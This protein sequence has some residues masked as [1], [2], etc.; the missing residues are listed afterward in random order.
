LMRN[1][2][3]ECKLNKPFPPQ[4]ASWSWC[5]HRN[6]NPKTDVLGHS[7]F[8]LLGRSSF[9]MALDTWPHQTTRPTI[10]DRLIFRDW[11]N[12]VL[13]PWLW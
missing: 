1:S 8:K 7:K 12:C 11:N 5:L 2:S 6:R 10:V 9:T 3:M 4:L 13:F